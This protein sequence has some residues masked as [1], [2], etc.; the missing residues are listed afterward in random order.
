MT[1]RKNI[2]NEMAATPGRKKFLQKP[3]SAM[4]QRQSPPVEIKSLQIDHDRDL[5]C[6]PYN[7]TGQFVIGKIRKDD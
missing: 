4:S 6:D 7:R 2:L 5:A 3:G 1:I